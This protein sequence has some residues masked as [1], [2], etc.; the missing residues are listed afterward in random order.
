[1]DLT[2]EPIDTGELV[3]AAVAPF[4]LQAEERR[5]K[6][7][8]EIEPGLPRTARVLCLAE[9]EGRNAV[10]LATHGWRVTGIDSSRTALEKAAALGQQH[11]VSVHWATE[12]HRESPSRLPRL[13]LVES[14][15]E[16][17]ALPDARLEL[18]VCFYYLQ[19]SLF[20]AIRRALR[21]G[22]MIVYETYTVEHLAFTMGPRN[23]E[24]LLRPRELWDAFSGFELVFYRE[25]R[26]GK[27]IASL[28]A[29]KP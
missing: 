8:V 4:H 17:Y 16:G 5:V 27:G 3:K 2:K 20:P 18:I 26:A 15:L 21:P 7:L 28:L 9:G 6:F 19:R 22:G 11:G 29:R 10:F 13:W 12:P 23:P 25:L 1:V 14:D 24:H